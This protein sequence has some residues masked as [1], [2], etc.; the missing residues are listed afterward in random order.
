MLLLVAAAVLGG[1]VV[2]GRMPL[3]A[4]NVQGYTALWATAVGGNHPGAI[5][6]GLTHMTLNLCIVGLYVA[7]FIWRNDSYYDSSKVSTGPLT[8][9]VI[10][11]VLLLASGWLG[12]MLAYRFGVRVADEITQAEGYRA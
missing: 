5:R 1:A 4:E 3:E 9:S 11:I 12:G 10:A 7:N 8:L 2:L 6:I